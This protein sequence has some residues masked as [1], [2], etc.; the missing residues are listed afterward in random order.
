MTYGFNRVEAPLVWAPG[1]HVCLAGV[2]AVESNGMNALTDFLRHL[3]SGQDLDAASAGAF[4]RD[5]AALDTK[6]RRWLETGSTNESRPGSDRTS[7][8]GC[9]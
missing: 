7:K 9:P 5:F 8:T 4:G 1:R 6:F 2:V 3:A